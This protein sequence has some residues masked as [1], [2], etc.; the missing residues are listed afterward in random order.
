LIRVQ[1]ESSE[2]WVAPSQGKDIMVM[3]PFSL[4]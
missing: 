1:A 4:N 3:N 2:K